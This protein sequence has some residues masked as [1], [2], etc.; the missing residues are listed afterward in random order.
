MNAVRVSRGP[1]CIAAFSDE[2]GLICSQD[3]HGLWP[4][5][6]WTTKSLAAVLNAPVAAAFVAV[7][8]N[9]L[10]VRKLTLEALP[11]PQLGT[12]EVETLGHYVD[13]YLRVVEKLPSVQKPGWFSS[14]DAVPVSYSL[15]EEAKQTLLQIDALVLK[16]YNLPPRLERQLLDFFRGAQRPVPFPF[17]EYFPESFL[18]TIPLWMYISPEYKKCSVNY[19]LSKVPKITDPVLIEALQEVE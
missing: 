15:C 8:E 14:G 19:F 11:L 16:G 12:A 10:H 13:R 7:R 18:P 2:T 4:S 3:F 6:K 5:G 9:K 17:T 1:W